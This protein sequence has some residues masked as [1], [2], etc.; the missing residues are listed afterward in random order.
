MKTTYEGK[1]TSGLF[2]DSAHGGVA[3]SVLFKS[4]FDC[5]ES[6][7]LAN[8]YL[9]TVAYIIITCFIIFGYIHWH[10]LVHFYHYDM[11]P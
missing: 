4:Q 5:N 11:L 1:W 3:A 6:C 8:I 10:T 7:A 9:H 2:A